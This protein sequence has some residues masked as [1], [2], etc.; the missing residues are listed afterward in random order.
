MKKT[1][2]EILFTAL[3]VTAALMAAKLTID[4]VFPSSIETVDTTTDSYSRDRVVMLKGANGQ[5]TGVQVVAPSGLIYI[6]TARHCEA[7]LSNG[8]ATAILENGRKATTIEIA[9]DPNSD[10]MLMTPVTADY[11]TIAD[12]AMKYQRVHTMTHGNGLPSFRTDGA[13]LEVKDIAIDIGPITNIIDALNCQLKKDQV[14]IPGEPPVCAK[15]LH[16]MAS[17]AYVIPGSSGGPLLD[18]HNRVVGIASATRYG[19]IVSFFVTLS[20]IKRFLRNH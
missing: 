20:D 15:K 19:S 5:C 17:T 6:L 7:I 1:G 14:I 4:A 9:I 8:R 13:L 3:M 12:S 18:A 16:S 2:L 11:L 10:L